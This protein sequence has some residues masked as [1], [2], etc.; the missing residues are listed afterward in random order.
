MCRMHKAKYAEPVEYADI[1]AVSVSEWHL[2]GMPE[3]VRNLHRVADCF[4]TTEDVWMVYMCGMLSVYIYVNTNKYC[5]SDLL[6][7][8]FIFLKL[9]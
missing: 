1:S 4:Q 7:H 9:Y 6:T 3:H 2:S 5:I 8:I